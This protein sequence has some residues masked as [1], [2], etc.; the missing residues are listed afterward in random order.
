MQQAPYSEHGW[1]HGAPGGESFLTGVWRQEE[2]DQRDEPEQRKGAGRLHKA[3]ALQE[4]TGQLKM[5]QKGPCFLSPSNRCQQKAKGDGQ[6]TVSVEEMGVLPS[7]TPTE[8]H[9][10]PPWAPY[11]HQ[12][13]CP[14]PSQAAFCPR[15]PRKE[16]WAFSAPLTGSFLLS[17]P[18]LTRDNR[19]TIW[20][21][22]VPL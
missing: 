2:K 5:L 4:G 7:L 6:K 22:A 20:A 12:H 18:S 13:H 1:H 16:V 9:P 3:E 10:S 21:I 15:W 17:P 19:A 11:R 14:C 8:P